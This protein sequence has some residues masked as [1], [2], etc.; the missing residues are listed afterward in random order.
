MKIIEKYK[1]VPICHLHNI[2]QDIANDLENSNNFSES[3][4][5]KLHKITELSIVAEHKGQR[6]ENRLKEY[7]KMIENL[8]F[9]R[10]KN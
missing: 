9:K 4:L 7:K 8:G 6:M 2:I 10:I 1:N 3:S 5:V